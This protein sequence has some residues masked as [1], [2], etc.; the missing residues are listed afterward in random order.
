MGLT[1]ESEP[2]RFVPTPH[3]KLFVEDTGGPGVPLLL[4]HGNSSCRHVFAR[5]IRSGLAAR[6]RLI[7]F[8]LPGHGRSYDA[9]D[10]VRTYSLPGLAD[11]TVELLARLGVS[12]AV[13]LGWSLGGHI[14]IEMLSRFPGMKGLILTGAPP[15][16]RGGFAEGFAV[17]PAD[18]LAGRR[19]LS[20]VEV[21]SFARIMF[22]AP[23][24][25]F[26]RDAISRSDGRCRQGL[27]EASRAGLG[28]D[29]RLAVEGSALPIAVINGAADPLIRLDYVESVAYR[30][31]WDRQCHR[32]G[33]VGHA[34][35]WHAADTFNALLGRF[36]DELE[37]EAAVSDGGSSPN[38]R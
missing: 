17:A 37:S 9:N 14:G 22:G 21:D 27:F 32:L 12:D 16:R 20:E 31:L 24:E 34:A 10:P 3:G 38:G 8:D 13:V 2:A 11:C 19:H 5:Q 18:G 30:K 26:L 36:L 23:V 29:Q 4:I 7:A 15:I 28:V 6:C 35:F 25:P 33:G 1:Q